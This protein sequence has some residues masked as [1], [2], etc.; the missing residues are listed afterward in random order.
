MYFENSKDKSAKFT[1]FILLP[2]PLLIKLAKA[3]CNFFYTIPCIAAFF[4]PNLAQP[5]IANLTQVL[6]RAVFCNNQP[7]STI[8]LWLILGIEII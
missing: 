5:S 1:P 3:Y 2:N 7:Q 8:M 4:T 6:P